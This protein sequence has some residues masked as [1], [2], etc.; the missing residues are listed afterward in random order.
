MREIGRVLGIGVA[1][2]V[3]CLGGAACWARAGNNTL[4][5]A[6]SA[7]A[8]ALSPE[9]APA[10]LVVTQTV[11]AGCEAEFDALIAEVFDRAPSSSLPAPVS[12]TVRSPASPRDRAFQLIAAFERMDGLLAWEEGPDGRALVAGLT[13][14]SEG[15]VS[16]QRL[17]GA[18]TLV[19]AETRRADVPP[20]RVSLAALT[21][22][23]IFPLATT[24]SAATG[25]LMPSAPL[26]ARTLVLTAIVAPS[27]TFVVMPTLNQLFAGWLEPPAAGCARTRT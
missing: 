22:L 5:S 25:I 12:T 13:E 1:A 10:T 27:M 24:V 6:W 21:W 26:L 4:V 15:E 8:P 9:K 2:A 11:K 19:A 18:R 20:D 3:L 17:A 23:G 16:W 7:L 14:V